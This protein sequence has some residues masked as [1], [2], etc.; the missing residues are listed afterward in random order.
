MS[1]NTEQT[2]I[3]LVFTDRDQ[4]YY[5]IPVEVFERGR[6]PAEHKAAVE[7]AMREQDVS[8]YYLSQKELIALGAGV[9]V[10]GVAA[11]PRGAAAALTGVA[12][13]LSAGAA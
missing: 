8:G 2:N 9:A 3:S 12:I 13:G 11:G 4:N 6:V 1:D 5:L 10:A 7:E